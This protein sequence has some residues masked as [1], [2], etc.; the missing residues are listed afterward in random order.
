MSNVLTNRF[1]SFIVLATIFVGCSEDPLHQEEDNKEKDEKDYIAPS[2]VDDYSAVAT[3]DNRAMW[4]LANVHDPSITYDN[5]YYY[6]YTTDAS[7]G[8]AHAESSGHYLARRSK[9]LVN[10]DFIG[11]ATNGVPSWIPDSLNQI[12]NRNGLESI[13]DDDIV[14]GF[15]APGVNEYNGKYRM[16][17]SV[18]I[19]NYIGNGKPATAENFD[20]TWTERSFI[21]LRES[22]SLAMNLW[23]D[24]GMVVTSVSDKGYKK[25]DGEANAQNQPWYRK[26]INSWTDAYSKYNAIDPAYVITPENKHW[27]IY[28]SWHSGLVALELNPETGLPLV[29]FNMD[30]EST[31]GK[32]IYTRTQGNYSEG[33]NRWQ[34]SEG[35]EVIYNP[36]TKY[37][38]LFVAYDGLDVPYN[39]RVVRSRN[40]DGPY[41]D[42]FGNDVTNGAKSSAVGTFPILTHPYKFNNHSGWVGFSHCSVFQHRET[43]NWFYSSQ[44]RLPVGT[45]SNEYSNAIMMGHINR[46]RWTNNAWPV[47]LPERYANVPD[48]AILSE[49]LAGTWEL[50][51]LNYEVGVMQS[52]TALTLNANGIASG[53]LSGKWEYNESTKVLSI[54]NQELCV[55]RE[56]DWELEPRVPTIVFSGLNESG[57]SLW[58]KRL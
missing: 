46:I 5:G 45:G 47:I 29:P 53:A 18:V 40:I 23:S 31:W 50:I 16:Y 51:V 15:W 34:G 56:L 35:P 41:E 38:Y 22:L 8:N 26:A 28:G 37:Y 12:R 24:R 9:D 11:M 48:D 30:D 55:E 4:N 36:E 42:Y 49:D 39:T 19:D 6:M 52:S 2:Y 44:A 27:L 21:G 33:W 13:L 3:W 32:R 54:G 7:Y 1:W 43:G 14:Y 20:N 58:G 57:V 25:Q 10:W 17:Y